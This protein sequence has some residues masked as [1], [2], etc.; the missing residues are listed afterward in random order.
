VPRVCDHNIRET[1]KGAGPC[2]IASEVRKRNGQPHWWCHTHG[3]EASAPDGKALDTCPAAWFDP[4][5]VDHQ[6]ELDVADGELAIWGALR[7][8]I[9]MGEPRLDKGKVHVHHRPEP[10]AAKD[11]DESYDIVRL[12][13]GDRLLLVEGMAAVAYSISLLSGRPVVPLTC[14]RC[15]ETH[16]DEQKFATFPHRKHLCNSCGRNFRDTGP[17]IS[18]PLAQAHTQLGLPDP[19][20]PQPA[21]HQ[22]VLDRQAYGAIS[23]WPSNAAIVSTMQRPEEIGVHVHAWDKSGCQV[24][25]ETYSP[26]ILDGEVLDEQA[27]RVLAVQ[28]ALVHNEPVV[29]LAC[30]TCGS[31]L[32]TSPDTWVEPSTSH[33]CRGCGAVTRTRRRSFVNPLAEK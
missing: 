4:V 6:I 2:Q 32:T 11:I 3:M 31:S 30:T 28:R 21:T 19:P 22:L 12:R 25:D 20:T 14:P 26:V 7:P 18:N 15:G 8:A 23:I 27:L 29:K 1:F 9:A 24:I 33:T 16:I 10:G 5:P 13:H 17:S